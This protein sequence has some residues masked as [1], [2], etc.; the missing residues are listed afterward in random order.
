MNIDLTQPLETNRGT[1]AYLVAENETQITVS[2]DS[3]NHHFD[4][5]TLV[6]IGQED[7][8]QPLR[9]RNV[10][11]TK[12][13]TRF[14]VVYGMQDWP[15]EDWQEIDDRYDF[16]SGADAADASK[17]LNAKCRERESPWRYAV[18]RKIV[19][20]PDIN[21]RQVAQSR[22]ETGEWTPAPWANEEWAKGRHLDHFVHLSKCD[23]TQLAYYPTEAD[24]IRDAITRIT[25]GKY[26]QRFF[27]NVLD[28]Q[29]IAHWV[30][31]IDNDV[32]LLFATTEDEIEAVYASGVN[33][34]MSHSVSSY[35]TDGYHPV[36][37]YAAGDLSL[38]YLKRNKKIC[39]RAL[40]WPERKKVG[41]IYG[42]ETRLM[43]ALRAEGYEEQDWYSLRGA[44]LLKKEYGSGFIMPYIDGCNNYGEHP[45]GI[46]LQI[47]GPHSATYTNGLDHD[48]SED[49]EVCPH[50]EEDYDEEDGVY[51]DSAGETWCLQCARD[52]ATRCDD[53]MDYVSNGS[54]RS[55]TV[56]RGG[57]DICGHCLE[58]SYI[59]V[60]NVNEYV[61]QD[62]TATCEDCNQVFLTN[63]LDVDNLCTTCAEK[64]EAAQEEE[65]AA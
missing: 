37:I 7:D 49:R 34:C 44:R 55:C 39:A 58:N 5:K 13:M 46:H 21:W 20:S 33:S 32:E 25:P 18:R 59:Y 27:D 65:L 16:E 6:L 1:S 14:L 26:L 42:D 57:D 56:V 8:D 9:L 11:A 29:Q 36:R 4:R 62:D 2:I 63:D 52:D 41:R 30:C 17:Q 60:D 19:E 28:S 54:S 47:G 23:A 64:A 51:I 10:P 43:N 38:A 35:Q 24:G 40:V 15:K 12:S 3:W 53:C 45:D 61:H 31:K 22:F 50:C 48:P